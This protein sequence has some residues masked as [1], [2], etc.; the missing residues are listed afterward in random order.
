MTIRDMHY[1]FKVKLNKID[2]Q[3]NRNLLVPEIDWMLNEAMGSYVRAI[4]QPKYKEQ[5]QERTGYEFNQRTIDDI[6]GEGTQL[7]KYAPVSL[8]IYNT[9]GFTSYIGTLPSD[10]M[11][12]LQQANV[13]ATKGSCPSAKQLRCFQ[14]QA[15]DLHLDSNFDNSSFEWR[16]CN[17]EIRNQNII[18]F[19]DGTFTPSILNILYFTKLPFIQNAQDFL[20]GSGQYYK[21]DGVTLLTGSLD[22]PLP[23]YVHSE[24]VDLAVIFAAGNMQMPDYR[25]KL[26]KQQLTQ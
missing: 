9:T 25:V 22:C 8:T 26:N 15:Q 10:Y 3:Q 21:P 6:R 19:T 23:S 1:D 2:S 17:I 11:F 20:I 4:V 7:V 24:I 5:I 18:V 16:E 12:Y 13:L 14:K